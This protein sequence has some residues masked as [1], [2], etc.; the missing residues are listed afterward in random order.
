MITQPAAIVDR[1]LYSQRRGVYQ[2]RIN[3]VIN[4]PKDR[5]LM[6]PAS[7]SPTPPKVAGFDYDA[8]LLACAGG[9]KSAL[10]ALYDV[11]APRMIGAAFRLLKQHTL[12]EDA[13]HDAFLNIWS[14]A[15]SFNPDLG[16][17]RAWIYA[18]LRN[19]ALNML[20]SEDR[21]DYTADIEQFGL[22]S[23]EE[24]PEAVVS[25]LSDASALRRCLEQLDAKRRSAIVLAYIHGLSHG[26]LAGRLNVPLGTMKSW[27]RRGLLALK[28]CLG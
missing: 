11:E 18:V 4:V 3:A 28:E 21:V 19:R 2:F 5:A 1:T 6:K 27:I 17:G 12:A 26:E 23:D 14:K 25:R 16:S 8:A 7:S 22:M 15:A 10:Q 13:V 9:D 20:R 24:D